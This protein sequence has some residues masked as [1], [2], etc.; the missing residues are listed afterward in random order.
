MSAKTTFSD[1]VKQMQEMTIYAYIDKLAKNHP[2]LKKDDLVELWN[3]TVSG[4]E[5][6]KVKEKKESTKEKCTATT[7]CGSSC[8]RNA[9]KNG[10]CA[11]H[12]DEKPEKKKKDTKKKSKK[13]EVDSDSD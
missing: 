8:K 7:K 11:T 6:S 12:S 4:F 1:L 10:K 2:D 5:L 3:T 9:V 13:E